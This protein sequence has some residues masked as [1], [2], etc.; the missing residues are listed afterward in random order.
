MRASMPAGQWWRPSSN[1]LPATWVDARP[2]SV[3][4][5]LGIQHAGDP[6]W[7]TYLEDHH[8]VYFQFNGV[9]NAESESLR[10]FAARLGTFIEQHE[11]RRL[12]IDM[13][14]NPGGDNTILRP[15]LVN[16]IRSKLN[17]RG[18]MYVIVGPKTFSAAQN[19]VNRLES[20]AEPIFLG[21]PTGNN[22]NFYADGSE[23]ELP[24]SHLTVF[25]S[26]L[27]WQDKDPTDDRT[28]LF[29][30]VAIT[31]Q[32]RD[33]VE[34]KDP[35]L[36][37]ALTT[38]TPPTIVESLEGALPQGLD[39]MLESYDRYVSSPEH[40]YQTD[41]ERRINGLG[42]RLLSTK[43]TMEAILVFETNARS[44]PGSA[45]AFDSLGDAYAKANDKEH[46]IE[47]YRRSLQLNPKNTNAADVL[48][49]LE[50]NH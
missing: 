47:A 12:V 35:V 5:P 25:A 46:A 36:Q 11:V 17:R 30:E 38:A 34:G 45:N 32:F 6:Y 2:Q 3:S 48:K 16:L 50:G 44:H 19:F 8:A 1:I 13:R 20:Y 26:H 43:R 49:Q 15:L 31:L 42:Y 39:A 9:I 41:S 14:N 27:W 18:G 21:E 23:I 4:I 29:P 33:Y 7:F 22:V 10:D 28:A 37:M 40:K 24:H